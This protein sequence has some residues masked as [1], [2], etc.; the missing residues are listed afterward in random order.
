MSDYNILLLSIEPNERVIIDS[1]VSLL[2]IYI[3]PNNKTETKSTTHELVF[4]T[5][6][7]AFSVGTLEE[8]QWAKE[9]VFNANKTYAVNIELNKTSEDTTIG[10]AMYAEFD[11]LNMEG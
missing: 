5:S 4:R 3:L 8:I 11:T 9:P 2:G 6:D 7:S 1:P 10:L